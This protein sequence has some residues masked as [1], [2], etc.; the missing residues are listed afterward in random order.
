LDGDL[1]RSFRLLWM[2]ELAA[3]VTGL[4]KNQA[5]F[6]KNTVASIL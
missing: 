1:D 2:G 6:V 3:M 5:E 4:E